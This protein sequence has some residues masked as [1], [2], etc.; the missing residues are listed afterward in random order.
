MSQYIVWKSRS[1]K[2]MAIVVASSLTVDKRQSFTLAQ[3]AFVY[4]LPKECS[5]TWPSPSLN[6]V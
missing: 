6:V 5:H 2:S 4:K 1:P 3:D